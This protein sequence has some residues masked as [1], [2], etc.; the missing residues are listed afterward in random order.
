MTLPPKPADPGPGK[1]GRKARIGD[2]AAAAGVSVGTVSNVLNGRGNVSAKRRALVEK[3][4]RDLSFSGSLLAKGMRTQRFPVVGLSIP[5][6][7]SSNFVLMSDALEAHAAAARFELVQVIT[8]H[9]PEREL[10]RI[11]RLIA[12]RVSGVL[13]LPTSRASPLIDRLV[14][15]R[16]PTVAINHFDGKGGDVDHVYVDHRAAFRAAGR[17][18]VDGGYEAL[19]VATQFPTFAVVQQ[20]IAGLREGVAD[21]GRAAEIAI[22]EAGPT[23]E[24]YRDAL[25]R[26]LRQRSVKTAV[27][28]S[29][30]LLAAWSIEAFRELGLRCPEDIG[31]LSAEEP[32][33]ADASW[34]ALACIQQPTRDLAR[35]AWDLLFARIGGSTAAPVTLRCE[36]SV[37]LRPSLQLSTV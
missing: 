7:T 8:R 33:W 26:S 1:T 12:T 28:A 36:S 19:I 20:N 37:N 6:A 11:D 15:A 29:S 22:L 32:Y 35:I 14:A 34:P 25:K 9:D 30:G 16:M 5:N 23:R 10:A 17:T 27:I 13:I 21:S 3:A 2:V 4:V 24:E 18:L 31:L